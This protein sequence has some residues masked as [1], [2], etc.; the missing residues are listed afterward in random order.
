MCIR[1]R[2]STAPSQAVLADRV[3]A[4]PARCFTM[5][6]LAN[7]QRGLVTLTLTLG[8]AAEAV[9]LSQQIHVDNAP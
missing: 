5:A 2:L 9:T 3:L 1:D 7:V 4:S 6:G 8:N